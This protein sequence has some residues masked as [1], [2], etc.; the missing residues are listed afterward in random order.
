MSGVRRGVGVDRRD[1][2]VGVDDRER[3]ARVDVVARRAGRGEVVRVH[4]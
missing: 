3:V 2:R 4:N 1:R